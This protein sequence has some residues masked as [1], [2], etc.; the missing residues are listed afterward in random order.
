MAMHMLVMFV[1]HMQ[2]IVLQ[3]FMDVLM[4]MLLGK[5]QPNADRHQLPPARTWP[6][7]PRAEP[8][9]KEPLPANGAVEK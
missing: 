2:V 5:V 3:L 8:T 4:C 9:R 7:E 1:V 6:T